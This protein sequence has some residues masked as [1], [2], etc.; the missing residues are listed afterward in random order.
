MGISDEGRRQAYLAALAIPVW[1][2]R[3]DL[4]H[5]QPTQALTMIPYVTDDVVDDSID[6]DVVVPVANSPTEM[7]A[8]PVVNTSPPTVPQD[9]EPPDDW[10]PLDAYL[11]DPDIRRAAELGPQSALG[12]A[13][14]LATLEQKR[15]PTEPK[16]EPLAPV[17]SL[18]PED[19]V[20]INF[21]FAL[22]AWGR[23]QAIIL[24]PLLLSPSEIRLLQQIDRA[25]QTTS[26]APLRFTWPM[27]ANHAVP[28]HK[29]AAREALTGFFR[30]Q[31]LAE[32]GYLVLAD[33]DDELTELLRSST[34]K[35]VIC[36]AS[37]ATMLQQPFRKKE[38][39]LTICQK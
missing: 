7:P 39:W 17:E 5:A 33:R 22:H 29:R 37:L 11:A 1:T 13:K 26:K 16:S 27:V 15:T 24:R 20:P 28:Q 4:V 2:A 3:H 10:P 19:L 21:A 6:V 31:G 36:C 23:W 9:G 32:Q 8:R 12:L 35:P 38:L 34:D 14:H 25:L 30:H 18:A